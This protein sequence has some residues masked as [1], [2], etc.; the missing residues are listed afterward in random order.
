MNS[1]VINIYKYICMYIY[2]NSRND[3]YSNVH[4]GMNSL[5]YTSVAY[6]VVYQTQHRAYW[7]VDTNDEMHP[8]D[9]NSL[10]Y[11]CYSQQ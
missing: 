4:M 9:L 1:Y 2:T 3:I 8:Q 7:S 11:W 5:V 10:I 6:N